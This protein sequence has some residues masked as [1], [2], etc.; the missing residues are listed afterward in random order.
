LTEA[1][2]LLQAM[3]QAGYRSPINSLA[4]VYRFGD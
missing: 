2:K 1:D 4:E 3:I